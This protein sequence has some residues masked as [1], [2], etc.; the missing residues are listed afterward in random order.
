MDRGFLGDEVRMTGHR[1]RPLQER[2]TR[3]AARQ[4]GSARLGS[5]HAE[6]WRE[7]VAG[8]AGGVGGDLLGGAGGND[9]AAGVAAFGAEVDLD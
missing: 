4:A 7:V 5:R 1:P 9:A 3:Y 2:A 6:Q 8:V